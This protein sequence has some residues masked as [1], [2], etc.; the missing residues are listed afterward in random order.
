MINDFD[1]RPD[2]DRDRYIGERNNEQKEGYGILLFANG[3]RYLGEFK[4]N[5]FEG[6]GIFHFKN[7]NILH[8]A[9]SKGV[10]NGKGCFKS[11]DGYEYYGFWIDGKKNGWGRMREQYDKTYK[12]SENIIETYDGD[13]LDDSFQGEGLFRNNEIS[14]FGSW[15]CGIK[16]GYG[17]LENFKT[18]STYEGFFRNDVFEGPG[19]LK[20]ENGC[21]FQGSFS[22]GMPNGNGFY[23]V[24]GNI[25]YR[26]EW[27]DGYCAE[28]FTRY[29]EEFIDEVL[30]EW[31]DTLHA[32]RL[33]WEEIYDLW[34]K[35][36]KEIEKNKTET[37]E[38]KESMTSKVS[39]L[40]FFLASFDRFMEE[41][42]DITLSN[43]CISVN[44]YFCCDWEFVESS[45]MEHKLSVAIFDSD[46]YLNRK[47]LYKYYS[48]ITDKLDSYK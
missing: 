25:R 20:F 9:F 19:H 29:L 13:W 30:R 6:E 28:L 16:S 2:K 17:K 36:F 1:S 3:D 33:E 14:Y 37:D 21:L 46:Y 24:K 45:N 43:Y 44:L 26:G 27:K 12:P 18:R 5:E 32:L 41:D 40:D 7:G 38:L 42:F 10:L 31:F 8:G 39:E 23:Q 15:D 34:E 35:K 22:N 11:I 4:N 47:I 48:L